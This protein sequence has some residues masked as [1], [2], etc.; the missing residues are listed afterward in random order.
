M[1]K[2]NIE[3]NPN[4][5][6]LFEALSSHFTSRP[7]R[8][9]EINDMNNRL[10]TGLESFGADWDVG[11]ES[12]DVDPNTINMG[13]NGISMRQDQARIAKDALIAS[14]NPEH[15]RQARINDIRNNEKESVITGDG[16]SED[17]VDPSM[18]SFDKNDLTKIQTYSVAYNVTAAEQGKFERALFPLILVPVDVS[19]IV[20]TADLLS[21][22]NF[23]ERRDTVVGID[24][25]FNGKNIIRALVDHT[26]LKN[27]LLRLVPVYRESQ[28]EIKD[29]FVP[30]SVV[31]PESIVLETGEK[32]K[33]SYI[34][35]DAPSI[36]YIA[37]CRTDWH[38]AKGIANN[39]HQ[40]ESG[41]QL[42]DLLISVSSTEAIRISN[43]NMQ[44]EA[45][46]SP[47][48]QGDSRE[49]TITYN[50]PALDLNFKNA[51]K[52]DGTLPS[53]LEPLKT[54]K[55]TVRLEVTFNVQLNLNSGFLKASMARVYVRGVFKEDGTQL[56]MTQGEGK[57]TADLFKPTEN[58]GETRVIGYKFIS[59][60]SNTNR[61]EF[62]QL[63]DLNR[64]SNTYA[65]NRLAPIS[66]LR[67]RGDASNQ[68]I[69][70]SAKV[71]AL[72][73]ATR[74]RCANSVV[75][76]LLETAKY[77]ESIPA[78]HTKSD[79]ISQNV[80]GISR[81]FL[82]CWYEHADL[83]VSK[84]VNSLRSADLMVDMQ[85]YMINNIREK[86]YRAHVESG[87]KAASDAFGRGDKK[88]K[89]IIAT[90]PYIAAWLMITG[91]TRTLGN[92]F[93]YEVVT[94][95]DNRMTGKLIF[96]FGAQEGYAEDL[97]NPMHF[98]NM[99]WRAE[100]VTVTDT[101]RQQDQLTELTVSPAWNLIV[102][103]PIMG[104]FTVKGIREVI[105]NGVNF[106]VNLAETG[107]GVNLGGASH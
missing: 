3:G 85:A 64:R 34:N 2:F 103:T 84:A 95:N 39:T 97:S 13:D 17:R 105:T 12:Y 11:L 76:T 7:I 30:E 1:K 47:S 51:L 26:I 72:V 52:V 74:I 66:F 89:V 36:D 48:A 20:T 82:S 100:R 81:Y 16:V 68:T 87:Y 8:E 31:E 90:D 6:K 42:S 75:T 55:H 45:S 107:E 101:S 83:D 38:N 14:T 21:V 49:M 65:I 80:L 79:V 46:F 60:L 70:E 57:T 15:V 99:A 35:I 10:K 41:V 5:K 53:K 91:D 78:N 77:L 9:A 67:A 71:D 61:N 24:N 25:Y 18:E 32:I 23:Y 86:V 33:T 102:H 29:L 63:L 94:T 44:P 69:A 59:R 58:K 22:M 62:G 73:M 93:E 50:N 40:I 104:V 37:L 92:D 54:S 96:V 19:S 28:Q 4:T 106:R 98:G 43:I 27:D 88:P 56:D